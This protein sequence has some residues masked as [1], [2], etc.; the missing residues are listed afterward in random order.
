M[1]PLKDPRRESE[2]REQRRRGKGG[3][4]AGGATGKRKGHH[5]A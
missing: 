1:D 3:C 2:R 5:N 4:G